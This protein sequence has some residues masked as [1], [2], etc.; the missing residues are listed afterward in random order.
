VTLTRLRAGVSESIE[1]PA[2]SAQRFFA[3]LRAAF[4]RAVF[5]AFVVF[6]QLLILPSQLG[7]SRGS[8]PI[9]PGIGRCLIGSA[10]GATIKDACSNP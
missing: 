5:S 10:R 9:S 2:S 4:L 3:V 7:Y 1:N 8:F 6:A